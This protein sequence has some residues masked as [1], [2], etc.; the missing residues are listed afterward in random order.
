MSATTIISAGNARDLW[1]SMCELAELGHY[2]HSGAVIEPH[3]RDWWCHSCGVAGLHPFP[4][5]CTR[6]WDYRVSTGRP[7][8]IAG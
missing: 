6:G 3:P 4:H 7:M 2:G 8:E 1:R 5:V